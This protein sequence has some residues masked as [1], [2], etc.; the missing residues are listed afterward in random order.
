VVITAADVEAGLDLG[1]EVDPGHDDL[2]G[3]AAPGAIEMG[4]RDSQLR[5][6]PDARGH[7]SAGGFDVGIAA[8][9][10]A[11]ETRPVADLRLPGA[12]AAADVSPPNE[13][14]VPITLRDPDP[15]KHEGAFATAVDEPPAHVADFQAIM[16]KSVLD[17]IR[18]HGESAPEKEV[19]GVLVGSV[20]E[21]P[22]AAFVYIDAAIRGDNANG[23]SAQVTFTAETWQHIDRVMEEKYPDKKIVGWYHTHP[24][25]GIFLSEM[26]LFIQKH[27]F[28]APWQTAFVFDPITGERGLFAWRGG[29]TKRVEFVVDDNLA[30]APQDVESLLLAK[31]QDAKFR[32]D[33]VAMSEPGTQPGTIIDLVDRVRVLEQRQRWTTVGFALMTLAAVAWPLILMV[34]ALPG[35]SG[36]IDTGPAPAPLPPA[37]PAVISR[38]SLE[39]ASPGEVGTASAAGAVLPPRGAKGSIEVRPVPAPQ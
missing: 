2:A 10:D 6:D 4:Q 13:P 33:V 18:S 29:E 21:N 39:K 11:V 8:V 1:D 12:D 25:F 31:P 36:G 30:A 15:D 14:E 27:F 35:S 28:N 19:C 24:G 26:D 5:T 23:R 16:Q 17:E 3:V 9:L 32:E 7:Q 22:T 20:Y 38:A 37:T 34:T